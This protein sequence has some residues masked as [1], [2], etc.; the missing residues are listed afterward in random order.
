MELLVCAH[1]DR[2]HVGRPDAQCMLP[3]WELNDRLLSLL[4]VWFLIGA[5]IFIA[6]QLR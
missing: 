5:V 1:R 6:S 4:W 3:D 2:R